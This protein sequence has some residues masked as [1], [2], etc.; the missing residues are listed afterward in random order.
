MAAV[1]RYAASRNGRPKWRQR[2]I[3]AESARKQE[4]RARARGQRMRIENVEPRIEA[5][6]RS[7]QAILRFTGQPVPQD[8]AELCE[9][10]LRLVAGGG[11]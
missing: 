10:S 6:C 5:L 7:V 1:R 2:D 11:Q 4:R 8:L 9:P 3:A